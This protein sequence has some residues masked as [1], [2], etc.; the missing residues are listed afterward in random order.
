MKTLYKEVKKLD[1]MNVLWL[2]TQ[3]DT[4]EIK[5]LYKEYN[6]KKMKVYRR[7]KKDYV[8]ELIIMNYEI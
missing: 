4:K 5:D 7:G 2:M 6:I 1:K 8:N 3:A